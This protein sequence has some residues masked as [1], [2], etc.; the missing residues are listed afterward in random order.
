M[1]GMGSGRFPSVSEAEHVGGGGASVGQREREKLSSE[2]KWLFVD[3]RRKKPTCP[4]R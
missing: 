3:E 1:L 2:A 4:W